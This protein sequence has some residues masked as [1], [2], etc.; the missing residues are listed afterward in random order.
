[1]LDDL[2]RM[3]STGTPEE[4][5]NAELIL[6]ELMHKTLTGQRAPLKEMEFKGDVDIKG[7]EKGIFQ[8][9]REEFRKRKLA[10]K[11]KRDDEI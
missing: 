5:A 8:T 2:R 6:N 1:M 4:K 10:E 11:K 7:K 9:M 3:E